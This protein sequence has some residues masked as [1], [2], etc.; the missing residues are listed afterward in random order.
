REVLHSQNSAS[1]NQQLP[2]A[3]WKTVT[4]LESASR[5]TES[6]FSCNDKLALLTWRCV[7]P[8]IDKDNSESSRNDLSRQGSNGSIVRRPSSQPR[9][10][11]PATSLSEIVEEQP[12][13]IKVKVLEAGRWDETEELNPEGGKIEQLITDVNQ[14]GCAIVAWA[15]KSGNQ[16]LV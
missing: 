1:M 8:P 11:G 4:E 15:Q 3:D 10:R 2:D 14:Q 5:S 9:L 12:S 13:V 7:L 6:S 16:H